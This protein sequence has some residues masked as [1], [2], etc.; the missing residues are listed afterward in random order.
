M[1]PLLLAAPRELKPRFLDELN[2]LP[3]GSPPALEWESLVQGGI[4]DQT[5]KARSLPARV[6]PIKPLGAVNW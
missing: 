3:T 1:R 2:G 6:W 5:R 4:I